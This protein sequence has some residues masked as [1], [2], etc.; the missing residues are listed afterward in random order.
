MAPQLGVIRIQPRMS[1]Y[2]SAATNAASALESISAHWAMAQAGGA[3]GVVI[4][5]AGFARVNDPV[6]R[7]RAMQMIAIRRL[8]RLGTGAAIFPSPCH[9]RGLKRVRESEIANEREGES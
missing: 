5:M 3:I 8:F 7:P 9:D 4:S 2:F 1:T 6:T